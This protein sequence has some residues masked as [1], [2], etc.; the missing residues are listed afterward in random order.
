M[1][2]NKKGNPINTYGHK[3]PKP[4]NLLKLAY[5]LSL[6]YAVTFQKMELLFHQN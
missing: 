3:V 6:V 4:W 2:M 1:Y 5:F